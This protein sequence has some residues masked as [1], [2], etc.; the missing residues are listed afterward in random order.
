MCRTAQA[1][2]QTMICTVQMMVRVFMTIILMIEN[3]VRMILQTLYNFVSFVMQIISL[4]PICVVFMVTARLKCFMCGG[5]GGCP[6]GRGGTC[7][8]VMSALAFVIIFLI[9]RVTG[10]LDKIFYN[11][12]YAKTNIVTIPTANIY[13]P[14][15]SNITE[16]SRGP[17]EIIDNYEIYTD[18]E[19]T[20]KEVFQT[21]VVPANVSI[22]LTNTTVADNS[23]ILLS[24]DTKLIPVETTTYSNVTSNNT[25][26]YTG[27]ETTTNN[28]TENIAEIT[29]G[30]L[31]ELNYTKHTSITTTIQT[32][33]FRFTNTKY[34]TSQIEKVSMELRTD[35]KSKTISKQKTKHNSLRNDISTSDMLTT[36]FYYLIEE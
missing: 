34:R 7:D 22:S 15:P 18:A 5:G 31:P 27:T 14:P 32:S 17:N 23:T 33:T 13:E 9:F 35:E 28:E 8:C 36:I 11:L 3:L 29:T 16:C 19:T 21:N 4:I 6:V 26:N 1:L 20:E 12:G 24:T 10:V 25:I 30:S 2:I